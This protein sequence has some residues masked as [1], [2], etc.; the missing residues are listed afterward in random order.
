MTYVLITGAASDVAVRLRKLLKSAYPRIRWS[1]IRPAAD[2]GPEDEFVLA[3][4]GDPA[5]LAGL[6]AGVDSIVHLGGFTIDGEWEKVLNVNIDG[7]FRLFDAAYRA[8]VQR[9]V[10]ASSNHAVGFY[11]RTQ[12]I[13]VDVTVRPDSRYGLAKAF[14]E[15][16]GAYYADKHGLRV[17]C[18]RIGFVH[19]IPL[20]P[21]RISIWTSPDD[22]MQLIRI[23]LEHPDIHYEIF[24]GVS[25]NTASWYDNGRAYAFGYKPTGNSEV[26]RDQVLAEHRNVAVNPI[27]ERFQGGPFASFEYDADKAGN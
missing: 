9:V 15:A 10:F 25:D 22:L 7:V 8:G 17:T 2:L 23:G 12:R 16:A 20:D 6:V 24:Y 18:I 4:L 27:A 1:D 26:F 21:R 3:D 5:V 13:G 11:E 14:G 19:D